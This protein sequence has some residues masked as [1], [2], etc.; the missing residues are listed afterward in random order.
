MLFRSPMAVQVFLQARLAG[1]GEF[2]SAASTGDPEAVFLGRTH[3]VSLLMEV[4]PRALLAELGLS[5]ML[6]GTSGAGQFLL[7]L[8][9]E[10][11]SAAEDFMTVAARGIEALSGGTL[12]LHWSSTENLGDWSEIRRRLDSE[13]SSKRDTPWAAGVLSNTSEARP[14]DSYFAVALAGLRE[15]E[16][17]GWSPETPE[18]VLIG[19]EIGRAHV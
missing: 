9:E 15:A 13:W 16:S 7:L 1:I 19:A 2:L 6:L 4:V 17:I 12:N 8:P 14:D 5:K 18:R 11:R 10:S 3:W